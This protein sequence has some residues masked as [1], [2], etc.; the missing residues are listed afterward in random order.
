M[1]QSQGK[2]SQT[3]IDVIMATLDSPSTENRLFDEPS[4]TTHGN[5]HKNRWKIRLCQ[6][7]VFGSLLETEKLNRY[8]I[9]KP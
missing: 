8:L 1:I 9:V 7:T 3:G 2:T 4:E 6:S 5:R